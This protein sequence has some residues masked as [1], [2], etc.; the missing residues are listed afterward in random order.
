MEWLKRKI[1]FN[2]K[3]KMLKIRAQRKDKTSKTR[4]KGGLTIYRL[5]GW[6]VPETLPNMEHSQ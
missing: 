4:N 1:Y 3:I 2:E 6:M 5:R